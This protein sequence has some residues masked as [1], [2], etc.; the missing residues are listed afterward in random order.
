MLNVY[1]AGGMAKF[2]KENF[3]EGNAWR[4]DLMGWFPDKEINF[5]NPALQFNAFNSDG[6]SD[7]MIMDFDLDIV[8]KSDLIIVGF[9]DPKSIGTQSE[10]AVAYDRH[11]PIYGINLGDFELHPWQK[12]MCGKIFDSIEEITDFLKDHYLKNMY[13]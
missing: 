8:R 4:E 6:F 10:L 13:V 1:L 2:G 3:D 12:N 11:I 7:K 9:N 5:I